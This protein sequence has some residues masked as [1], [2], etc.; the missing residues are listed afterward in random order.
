MIIKIY[1]NKKCSYCIRAKEKA[2]QLKKT[3]SNVQYEYIDMSLNK[4]STEEVSKLIGKDIRTVPQILIDDKYI[5]G[6]K[7]FSLYL[8]NNKLL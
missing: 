2:E 3:N 4:I 7:D 1:G 5:G 6:Y 8:K